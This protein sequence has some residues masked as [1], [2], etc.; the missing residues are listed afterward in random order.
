MLT[1]TNAL[2]FRP[3]VLGSFTEMGGKEKKPLADFRSD[4]ADLVANFVHEFFHAIQAGPILWTGFGLV[5]IGFGATMIRLFCAIA[6]G[7]RGI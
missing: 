7:R 1:T 6:N 5:R 2:G 4:R 3:T